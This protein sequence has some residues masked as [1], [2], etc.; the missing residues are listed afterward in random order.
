[1]KEVIKETDILHLEVIYYA[2]ERTVVPKTEER[3][4]VC[5]SGI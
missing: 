4:E 5:L 3:L 1:M 2:A